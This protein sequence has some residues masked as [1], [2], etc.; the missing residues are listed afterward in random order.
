MAKLIESIEAVNRFSSE[1]IM[2]RLQGE[3][4]TKEA[5]DEVRKH[6]KILADA[7]VYN[8]NSEAVDVELL[9]QIQEFASRVDG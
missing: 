3:K 8:F 1:M 6:C 4:P 7:N 9:K 5:I 2:L